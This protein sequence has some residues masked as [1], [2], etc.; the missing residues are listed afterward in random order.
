[1]PRLPVVVFPNVVLWTCTYLR[2]ELTARG[3]ADV[4]VASTYEQVPRSVWVRRDGGPQLDVVRESA[5][6]GINVFD[7]TDPTGQAVDDLAQLV[8]ALIAACPDGRPVVGVSGITGPL[9][10]DDPTGQP[11]RYLSADLIVR[12]TTT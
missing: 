8:R 2:A 10:I 3:H 6:L 5:R 9:Q 7:A 1:M 4:R 12:G 11:R